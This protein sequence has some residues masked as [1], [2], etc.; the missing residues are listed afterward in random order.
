ME[1]DKIQWLTPKQLREQLKIS[2][3]TLRR[4][5]NTGKVNYITPVSNHRLYNLKSIINATK[6]DHKF[7]SDGKTD[8]RKSFC[9]CRVSSVKQKDDLD[10]Q[11]Q[12]MRT[13]FPDHSIVS[14]IG[15][16]LNW[17]RHNFRK[18]VSE[19]INGNIKEI[20]IAHRVRLCRFGFEMLEFIFEKCNVKLLVLNKGEL[21]AEHS[22]STELADD[23]LSIIHIFNCRQMGKRRYSNKI[24][25][26]SNG[27][28]GKANSEKTNKAKAKAKAKGKLSEK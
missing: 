2:D 21:T 22:E 19:S 11:I 27:I 4:W 12:Y 28:S 20:V 5:A 23:L 1:N 15:S 16:G 6:S 9:Y 3:S 13:K 14:D 7:D 24:P 10:R 26:N 17:K 8:S 25:K 18:L